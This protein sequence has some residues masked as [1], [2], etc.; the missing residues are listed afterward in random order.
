M[1]SA[2]EDDNGGGGWKKLRTGL[3]VVGR[4]PRTD[5]DDGGGWKK[6]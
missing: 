2:L 4:L 5:D 1:S 6:L 3:L